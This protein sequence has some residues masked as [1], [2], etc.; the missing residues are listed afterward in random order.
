MFRGAAAAVWDGGLSTLYYCR[1]CLQ[2]TKVAPVKGGAFDENSAVCIIVCMRTNIILDP[3]LIKEAQKLTGIQTKKG[4]ID[5]ALRA[6]IHNLKRK[7]LLELA[8]KIKFAKGYDY[9]ATR[10]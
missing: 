4:V 6:L 2:S 8:G 3:Q 1:C 9:K 5:E 7:S 10:H